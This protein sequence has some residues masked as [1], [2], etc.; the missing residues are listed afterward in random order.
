MWFKRPIFE[1]VNVEEQKAA[2]RERIRKGAYDHLP[3]EYLKVLMDAQGK[4]DFDAVPVF[5]MKSDAELEEQGSWEKHPYPMR[6]L[7]WAERETYNS[8]ECVVS[9]VF[10]VDI[11]ENCLGRVGPVSNTLVAVVI[12][13]KAEPVYVRNSA[14]QRNE[15]K[16]T[17]CMF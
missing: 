9:A 16:K 14:G 4:L 17:P 2:V 10:Q 3:E 1:A 5:R 8:T 12:F 15:W 6:E 7:T 11:S 13:P